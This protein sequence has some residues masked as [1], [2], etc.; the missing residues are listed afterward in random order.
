MFL[1]RILRPFQIDLAAQG[2]QK[3]KIQLGDQI[4]EA[5]PEESGLLY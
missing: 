3:V 1:H 4:K 5:I 2:P